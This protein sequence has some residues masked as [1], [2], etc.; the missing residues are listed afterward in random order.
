MIVINSFSEVL[1]GG[2][3]LLASNYLSTVGQEHCHR[4]PTAIENELVFNYIV[5]DWDVNDF[6]GC[7]RNVTSHLGK[8][9]APQDFF[10]G[11]RTGACA[12]YFFANPTPHLRKLIECVHSSLKPELGRYGLLVGK[13]W[14]EENSIGKDSGRP[15]PNCPFGLISVRPY[16]GR[17]DDKFF[18]T[19]PE[20]LPIVKER[21]RQFREKGL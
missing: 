20:L 21:S 11:A 18:D 14:P 13:F 7:V 3:E 15:I 6:N 16:C 17:T 12:N 10:V 19:S 4:L 9:F 1:D 2:I 5:S 8:N